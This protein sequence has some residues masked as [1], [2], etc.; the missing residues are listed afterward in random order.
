MVGIDIRTTAWSAITI[1]LIRRKGSA[2][3]CALGVIAALMT[4]PSALA[5]PVLPPPPAPDTATEAV[6]GDVAATLTGVPHLPSPEN[7]PPGTTDA[8]VGGPQGPRLSYLRELWDAMH[9]Q[10]VSKSDALLLLAQ[11]PLD[12]NA[13]P[14]P[15]LPA[16]PQQPLP[17][18]PLPPT[19]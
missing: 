6:S 18:Q 5:D 12:P 19:P 13:V 16:G 2:G 17:A 15:G 4:A 1:S 10:G 7:L 3:L 8:P 9:T 11:R 14:P